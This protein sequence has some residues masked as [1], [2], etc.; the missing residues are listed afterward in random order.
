MLDDPEVALNINT[1]DDMKRCEDLLM[2][3]LFS[4]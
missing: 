1:V 2:K 4:K 3:N